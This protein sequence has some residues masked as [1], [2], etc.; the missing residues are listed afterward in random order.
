MKELMR[1]LAGGGSEEGSAVVELA[2]TLPPL[3][4]VVTGIMVFGAAMNNYL[5]L[6]NATNVAG[7]QLAISRGQTTDPCALASATVISAAPNLTS[8]KL[9]YAYVLNGTSYSGTSCSSS[10]SS[11]GAAGNLQQGK[12]A[13]ITVTYPCS[14]AVYGHNYSPT[15]NLQAQVTELV[16]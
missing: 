16:Q 3:L 4:L 10:S 6:I 14:L 7:R 11:T 12:S 2:L 8:S 15:C 1:S 9:T 5:M 13:G